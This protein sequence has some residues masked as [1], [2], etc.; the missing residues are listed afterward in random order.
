MANISCQAQT[1]SNLMTADLETHGVHVIRSQSPDYSVV[2][3]RVRPTGPK[4][5]DDIL[6]FS[7]IVQNKGT[8]DILGVVVRFTFMDLSGHSTVRELFYNTVGQPNKIL[9]GRG[10]AHIITPIHSLNMD[11][12][13]SR[14]S[15]VL[16]SQH[17]AF[18]ERDLPD[19]VSATSF[20]VT[21]DTVVFADGRI[22]GQDASAT[23]SRLNRTRDAYR[24]LRAQLISRLKRGDD[25]DLIARWLADMASVRVY[26][27]TKT[28]R[29]D[30]YVATQ[31]RLAA[32]FQ[33]HLNTDGPGV[34]L[35]MLEDANGE[36]QLFVKE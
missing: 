26:K 34:V 36:P 14:D 3:Y 33:S 31:K 32:S 9:M 13:S 17:R 23:L 27:D 25:E 5:L 28:N 2:L 11:L 19:L 15:L 7:I 12:I 20:D 24:D 8:R 35:R 1:T 6:P 18:I 16:T 22:A 10:E 21:L 30:Y 29:I 4:G